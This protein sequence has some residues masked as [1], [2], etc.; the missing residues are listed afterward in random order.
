MNKP[1]APSG[2]PMR[3]RKFARSG[4]FFQEPLNDPPRGSSALWSG[5]GP[6]QG[7]AERQFGTVLLSYAVKMPNF[8]REYK[9]W[10]A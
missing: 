10:R 2:A 8:S 1:V 5:A 6:D 3:G 4:G 7:G 9:S